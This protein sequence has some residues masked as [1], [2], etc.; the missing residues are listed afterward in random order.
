MNEIKILNL[1]NGSYDVNDSHH[2]VRMLNFFVFKK[3]FCVVTELLSLNLYEVIKQNNYRGIS[4]KLLR[5]F[6]AQILDVL[7]I[8]RE[9]NILHFDLKPENILLKSID[10]PIIKVIDFGSS[11]LEN[12]AINMYIQNRYYRAPEDSIGL[13]YSLL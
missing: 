3:H 1:L 9:A 8:L 4:I 10:S 2:I 13:P 12:Q 6:L 11:C 7:C 5:I